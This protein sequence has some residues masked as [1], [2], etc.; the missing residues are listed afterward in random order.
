CAHVA[1]LPPEGGSI[2]TQTGIETAAIALVVGSA[3]QGLYRQERCRF[4]PERGSVVVPSGTDSAAA[5]KAVERGKIIGESLNLARELV[6]RHPGELYPET[7]AQRASQIATHNGI[8]CDVLDERR[9]TD[10]RM[11][12]LLGVARGSERPPRVV[13]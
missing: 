3:S 5:S 1:A 6:N 9:I 10:E 11:G 7:F 13:V 4:E 8:A 2:D 12:C